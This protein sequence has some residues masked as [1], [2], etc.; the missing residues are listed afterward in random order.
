MC[1]NC[2]PPSHQVNAWQADPNLDPFSGGVETHRSG[3]F[4]VLV[5]AVAVDGARVCL[6]HSFL[7]ALQLVVVDRSRSPDLCELVGK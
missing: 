4:K 2:P 5:F 6:F 1:L 7:V 3:F